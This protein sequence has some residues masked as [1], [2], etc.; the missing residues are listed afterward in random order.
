LNY[1]LGRTA[2]T[3]G[4]EARKMLIENSSSSR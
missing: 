3:G 2:D 1:A 4:M